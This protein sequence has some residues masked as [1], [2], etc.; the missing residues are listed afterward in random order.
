MSHLPKISDDYQSVST[1]R[2]LGGREKNR[3]FSLS[4][5]HDFC[6]MDCDFV[7]QFRYLV[8]RDKRKFHANGF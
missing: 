4:F 8:R 6:T 7:T 1:C 2:F 3:I 5:V